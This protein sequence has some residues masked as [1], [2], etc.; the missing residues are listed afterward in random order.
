MRSMGTWM[1]W[2]RIYPWMGRIQSFCPCRTVQDKDRS[3]GKT[4]DFLG[5]AWMCATLSVLCVPLTLWQPHTSA[6][7]LLSATH[8]GH[9]GT[10]L[11]KLATLSHR[12]N[13]LHDSNISITLVLHK[14]NSWLS[15]CRMSSC[16]CL[17]CKS[18]TSQPK[19][20]EKVQK[21]SSG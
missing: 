7:D 4:V 19:G 13:C 18:F 16:P 2:P 15:Y 9:K 17:I 1:L 10:K 20:Y 6:R 21:F 11:S 5:K 14:D 8:P 3:Q 12:G